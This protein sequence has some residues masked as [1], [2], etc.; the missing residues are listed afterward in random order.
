[1]R[2]GHTLEAGAC[3]SQDECDLVHKRACTCV[4]W[5]HSELVSWCPS[6]RGG[7]TITDLISGV[8][9]ENCPR[10][11]QQTFFVWIKSPGIFKSPKVRFKTPAGATQSLCWQHHPLHSRDS[12]SSEGAA[13]LH[14][15][16]IASIVMWSCGSQ[17]GHRKE[18]VVA[19]CTCSRQ[20]H[21]QMC[22]R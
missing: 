20:S 6:V 5:V 9:S 7:L 21:P 17:E 16:A 19:A 10:V 11:K 1:M 15:R 22:D 12:V 4:A 2:G 13:A 14:I 3:Y 18:V 8:R